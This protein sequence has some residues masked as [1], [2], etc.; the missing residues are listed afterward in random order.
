MTLRG[1]VSRPVY[2]TDALR[3]PVLDELRDLYRYRDLVWSLIVRSITARY[4]RSVLGILW[5]LLDPLLTM[6]VMT[7]VFTALFAQSLKNYPV[8][9]LS[10]LVI[11]NFFSQST[12]HA[13]SDLVFGGSLMGRVYMPRSVFAVAAVG[14]GLVNVVVSLVPLFLLM[15]LFQTPLTA[16]LLFVP[17]AL[18]VASL[19]SLGFGL[20]MSA[21][22][23]HF[24]DMMNIHRILLRLVMYLSGVFYSLDA[25]PGWLRP[26]V[27]ANPVYHLVNL[28]RSPIYDG[29]L[30]TSASV[31][32]ATGV[33]AAVLF[34][35]YW[36]YM[37]VSDGFAYRL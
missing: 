11:W 21:L 29:V 15:L 2:D 9:I 4:K 13:M 28:F 7:V 12:T 26:V 37:R 31:L 20:M 16:A 24:T 3:R 27:N 25:L 35:G 8:F 33:S 1:V 34:V 18:V 23:V 32:I 19:F 30:P 22:A 10:G 6:A 5:T 14:A 36:I 17:L